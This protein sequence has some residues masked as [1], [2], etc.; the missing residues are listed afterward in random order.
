MRHQ[1]IAG[2]ALACASLAC[3]AQNAAEAPG[4]QAPEARPAEKAGIC[5]FTGE[6]P[7][8]Y[9]YTTLE[10]L[11]YGKGSYGSV[12]DLLPKVVADAQT[13]GADAIIHYNGA[14]HFGFWPWRFVRPVVTGVA[15]KW[16]P[17]R[18]I[19]CAGAGGHYTTGTLEEAPP[20]PPEEE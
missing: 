14:Q 10:E 15:V 18:D 19:D 7:A 4:A 1:L 12:N 13:L 16:E 2:L 5:L 17:A 20:A 8:E 11:D 3:G 6:P 9:T